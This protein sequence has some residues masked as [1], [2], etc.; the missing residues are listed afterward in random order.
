MSIRTINRL[1]FF[2]SLAGLAVSAFLAFEYSQ[3]SIVCP[4]S[5]VGCNIVR[6]SNY[7]SFLGISLPYLGITFYLTLAILTVFLTQSF[8]LLFQFLR[9]IITFL[10]FAFGIYLTFLEAFVIRA[11]CI[12]CLISFIISTVIF[13]LSA[14]NPIWDKKEI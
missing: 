9:L 3:S 5:G 2:L 6:K 1:I 10:G 11:F 8:N 13:V 12:W 14:K 7:S 4:I